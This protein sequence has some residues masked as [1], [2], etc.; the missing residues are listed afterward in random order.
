MCLT[1]TTQ[2]AQCQRVHVNACS[3]TLQGIWCLQTAAKQEMPV[4]LRPNT[5]RF[6]SAI[7][8]QQWGDGGSDVLF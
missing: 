6:T 8:S 3:W 7:A 1:E 2:S 5:S 4:E